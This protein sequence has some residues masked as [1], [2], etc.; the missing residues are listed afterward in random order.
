MSGYDKGRGGPPPRAPGIERLQE[1]KFED[2]LLVDDKAPPQKIDRYVELLLSL[3]CASSDSRL[4]FLWLELELT[5][6]TDCHI[7]IDQLSNPSP[8]AVSHDTF[9]PCKAIS[10]PLFRPASTS[11]CILARRSPR[12]RWSKSTAMTCTGM[13][14]QLP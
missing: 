8:H 3:R 5:L 11:A 1:Y 12:C 14:L 13:R 9:P 2:K 4:Y 7:R 6:N 10:L